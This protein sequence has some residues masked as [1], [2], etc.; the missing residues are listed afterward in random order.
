M[1]R[2]SC[3]GIP[4]IVGRGWEGIPEY[5]EGRARQRDQLGRGLVHPLE[6]LLT[7]LSPCRGQHHQLHAPVSGNRAPLGESPLLQPV[8]YPGRVRRVA[9]PLVGERSHGS[10]RGDVEGTESA[11]IV[12]RQTHFGEYATPLHTASHEEVEHA[13]PRVR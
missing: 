6:N 8:N 13:L 2:W 5:L 1:S 3:S 12:W 10:A 4:P 7:R 11:S 9:A